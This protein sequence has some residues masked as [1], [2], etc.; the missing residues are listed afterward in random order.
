MYACLT[1]GAT[2][3]PRLVRRLAGTCRDSYGESRSSGFQPL[4][5]TLFNFV[6]SSTSDSY[7]LIG[8]ASCKTIQTIGLRKHLGCVKS[9]A[10]LH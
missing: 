2:R 1:A 7:G 6:S 9:T 5:L 8:Y 3:R 10:C 4:L